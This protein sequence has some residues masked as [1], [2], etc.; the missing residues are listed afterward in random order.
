MFEAVGNRIVGE[1][2]VMLYSSES[3]LLGRCLDFAFAN[4]RGGAIMIKGGYS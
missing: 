4:D 1:T 2:F 3:F